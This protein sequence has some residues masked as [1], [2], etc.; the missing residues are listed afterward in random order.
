MVF[1][2]DFLVDFVVFVVDFAVLGSVLIL[3]CWVCWFVRVCGC[4]CVSEEEDDDGEK[5]PELVL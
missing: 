4:L 2:V 3:R 5:M 1:V